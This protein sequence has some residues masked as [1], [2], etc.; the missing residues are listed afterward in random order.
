MTR[1]PVSRATALL[2]I[3]V[4]SAALLA[5]C[6]FPTDLQA[7]DQP[8]GPEKFVLHARKR[9]ETKPGSGRFHAVTE[10]VEWDPHKTALVVCD[11]WDK[12]WCAGA[13]RRVGEMAPRMNEVVATA[14]KAGAL[15]IHCPSDTL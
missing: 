12:H 1:F 11:M 9:V 13:T 5:A 2:T 14:R 8:A 15:I 10:T 7:K 6:G 4:G 3:V